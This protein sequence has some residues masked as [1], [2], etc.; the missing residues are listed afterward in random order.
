V[1]S[2]Q[3]Q[4]I[5]E[6][7]NWIET[8]MQENA[9]DNLIRIESSIISRLNINCPTTVIFLHIA[10]AYENPWIE[11]ILLKLAKANIRGHTLIALGTFL[12][13]EAS[14]PG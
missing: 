7:L 9:T 6:S 13:E 8:N 1:A 11:G 2:V 12:P 3:P 5:T 10:K 14:E 4:H